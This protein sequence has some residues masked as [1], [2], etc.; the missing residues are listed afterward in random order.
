M[1]DTT[2]TSS[3]MTTR[4][5]NNIIDQ[6]INKIIQMIE[7]RIKKVYKNLTSVFERYIEFIKKLFGLNLI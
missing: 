5:N 2:T 6:L 4:Q 3:L 7:L 1:M